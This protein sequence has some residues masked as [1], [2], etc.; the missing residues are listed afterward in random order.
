MGASDYLPDLTSAYGA[1]RFKRVARRFS[2]SF[3][4]RVYIGLA[5]AGA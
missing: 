2:L 4:F 3:D 5:T 1:R